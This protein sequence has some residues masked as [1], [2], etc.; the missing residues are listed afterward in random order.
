MQTL[1]ECHSSHTYAER[2]VALYW[3]G[4]RLEIAEIEKSWQSPR[5]KH[6]RVHTSE[7]QTFELLYVLS[8][9]YWVISHH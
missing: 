1:V 2:P 5:G 4:E 9:D 7:G 3:E 6:F 8:D